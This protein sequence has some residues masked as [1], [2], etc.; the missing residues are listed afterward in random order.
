MTQTTQISD[1]FEAQ[2]LNAA[3]VST[4]RLWIGRVIS[5]L[6]ALFLLLDGV[7]KLFKPAPVVSATLRLGYPESV[8]VGLGVVLLACTILYIVPATRVLGAILLTGYL[9]GAVATH[10]RAGS[11]LFEMTFPVMIG[12]L[13]WL[14]LVLRDQRVRALLAPSKLART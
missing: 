11:G 6:A 7:M 8:I 9:G 2:R 13:L 12:A 4:G 1:I 3:S 14:G 5:A 10:V